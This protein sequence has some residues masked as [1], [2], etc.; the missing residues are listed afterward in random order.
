MR[1]RTYAE[2]IA[3]ALVQGMTQDPDVFIMG[4]GVDDHKGIFGTTRPAYEKF[5]RARVFDV[6]IAEQALTGVAIGA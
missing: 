1:T 2:A 4:I 6:P 5:G 3:E